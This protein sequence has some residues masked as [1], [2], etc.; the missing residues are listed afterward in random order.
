M[1]RS[2]HPVQKTKQRPV[3]IALTFR[4]TVMVPEDWSDHD[5]EFFY[6]DSSHCLVNELAE[7]TNAE[8]AAGEGVCVTCGRAEVKLLGAAS[9]SDV[10][11][12]RSLGRLGG[13]ASE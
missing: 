9:D 6:N 8:E 7:L 10:E 4:M 3:K 5:I 11:W 13:K 12:E 1:N 2:S